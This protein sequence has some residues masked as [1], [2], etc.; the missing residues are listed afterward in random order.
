YPD[1]AASGSN[2][3]WIASDIDL[4]DLPTIH[5]DAAQRNWDPLIPMASAHD[6]EAAR[7]EGHAVDPANDDGCA[8]DI[9]I[10]S[11]DRE[12]PVQAAN[13]GAAFAICD[14]TLHTVIRVVDRGAVW[15]GG[16]HTDHRRRRQREPKKAA[17]GSNPSTR[18]RASSERDWIACA[19][20]AWIDRDEPSF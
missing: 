13:P 2:S 19:A 11:C 8:D 14:R 17:A 16:V 15:L 12:E 7:A 10:G 18:A 4:I 6:P 9:G 3:H 5:F 20:V 1:R